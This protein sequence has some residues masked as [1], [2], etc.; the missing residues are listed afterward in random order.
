MYIFSYYCVVDY[1]LRHKW[2]TM[3]LQKLNKKG[4]SVS[5]VIDEEDI[6]DYETNRAR[7]RYPIKRF[8]NIEL[9]NRTP[10]PFGKKRRVVQFRPKRSLS[11]TPEPLYTHIYPP[12]HGTNHKVPNNNYTQEQSDRE[13][14]TIADTPPIY[15]NDHIYYQIHP[16]STHSSKDHESESISSEKQNS[17][18]PGYVKPEMKKIFPKKKNRPP[19]LKSLS[20][21]KFAERKQSLKST[22]STGAMINTKVN[23]HSH[24]YHNVYAD[25]NFEPP[26]LIATPNPPRRV[27]IR[28]HK[29]ADDNTEAMLGSFDS[30]EVWTLNPQSDPKNLNHNIFNQK[31]NG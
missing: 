23:K 7:R 25:N 10:T 4:R 26:N 2:Q 8:P 16:I 6:I 9:L 1:R 27:I 22:K 11:I 17:D 12:L 18:L 21:K 29:E 3:T 14:S 19:L 20:E 30:G 13:S 28:S 15:Q 31:H 5:I 24:K